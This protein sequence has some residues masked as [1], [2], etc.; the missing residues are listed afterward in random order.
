MVVPAE[1]QF[2][3][4]EDTVAALFFARIFGIRYASKVQNSFMAFSSF[5]NILV[6]TFTASRVKQEIAKEG[7]L[8][9]T[10]FFASN[11]SLIPKWLKKRSATNEPTSDATP[12]G[13]L[14]LHW[15][16]TVLLIAATAASSTSNSYRI[17]VN[18]YSFV[19]DAFFG[20]A[21]GLGILVLRLRSTSHWSK[22]SSSNKYFSFITALIFTTANCFPLVAVWV[23]PSGSSGITLPVKWWATGTIGVG[24]LGFAAI[25]WIVLQY[26]VPRILGRDLEVDREYQF[27]K[28][29]DDYRIIWHEVTSVNWRTRSSFPGN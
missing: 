26:V 1:D 13:A 3:V 23:K 4:G 5:G 7:I 17:F 14:L 16:F 21:I 19:V 8:P 25:Y 10:K 29:R 2:K 20:F 15:T 11:K 12:V 18:L 27:R 6:Q 9:F 28:D 24:L 22:K